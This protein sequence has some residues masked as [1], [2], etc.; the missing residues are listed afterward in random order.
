MIVSALMAASL[1]LTPVQQDV[2]RPVQKQAQLITAIFI[3]CRPVIN[4][5]L[6]DQWLLAS[7][8]FGITQEFIS[9]ARVLVAENPYPVTET[10]CLASLVSTTEKLQNLVES[11]KNRQ[12]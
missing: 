8:D 3:A 4:P 12:Q 5:E 2:P 10:E 6:W 1:A 7:R 11:T 9:E